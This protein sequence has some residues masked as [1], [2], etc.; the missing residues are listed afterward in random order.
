MSAVNQITAALAAGIAERGSASFVVSGGSSPAPIF[1]AL[2]NS[3][4][5]AYVDWSKVTITLV[6][7]RLVHENHDD[8]NCKLIRAQLLQGPVSAAKF[9]PLTIAGPVTEMDRP[10]DVMLLGMGQDG[11]FASLFPSMVDD[12]AM[13]VDTPPAIVQTEPQGS[14]LCRRISMNL[15]MILQSRLVLLLVKGPA[16]KAVLKAA[17]TDRSLPLHYLI[18]Q[19]VKSVCV[20]KE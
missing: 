4:H 19:T 6:D 5:D 7:D 2:T 20:V 14:P 10:F 16:K 13:D 18:T 15:P 3:K 1:T 17:Q 11:H 12:A 9:L 8:S